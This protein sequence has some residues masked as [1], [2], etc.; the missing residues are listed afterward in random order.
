ML[1]LRKRAKITSM[2]ANSKWSLKKD[3][4]IE[5]DSDGNSG[6]LIDTNTSNY[7]SCNKTALTILKKLKKGKID[8]SQLTKEILKIN[9][10]S[11]TIARKD[12]SH[13][14]I[15]LKNMNLINEKI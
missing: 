3:V 12:I 14:L 2:N 15:K 10:I 7:C 11:Q 1:G 5:L 4:Y 13:F 9:T 8:I 6:M